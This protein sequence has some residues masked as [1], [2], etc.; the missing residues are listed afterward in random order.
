MM[1]DD[2]RNCLWRAMESVSQS[3]T[4]V[5][6]DQLQYE[7]CSGTRV[8]TYVKSKATVGTVHVSVPVH[9]TGTSGGRPEVFM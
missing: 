3:V 4:S 1:D 9:T 7:Y 8:R 6:S 5:T 2:A